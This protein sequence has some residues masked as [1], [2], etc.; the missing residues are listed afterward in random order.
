MVGR[1][2]RFKAMSRRNVRGNILLIVCGISVTLAAG[3]FAVQR[4]MPQLFQQTVHSGDLLTYRMALNSTVDYAAY[5]V[6]QRWCL[7]SNWLQNATC[8]LNDNANTERLLLTDNAIT[9][10]AARS[11]PVIATR[12]SRIEIDIPRSSL[13]EGHPLYIPLK[14][15]P[16]AVTSVLVVVERVDSVFKPTTDQQVFLRVRATLKAPSGEGM[17]ARSSS[18]Y[19]EGF[20]AYYPRE[21]SS[22]ALVVAGDLHLD[23]P[24]MPTSFGADQAGDGYIPYFNKSDIVTGVTFQSPVFVNGA[25][26]LP[27]TADLSANKESPV[28]FSDKIYSG[29]AFSGP[30]QGG[31]L[32]RD[33]SPF[34]P[35]MAS[36]GRMLAMA[37]IKGIRGIRAGIEV[38][39]IRDAGLDYLSGRLAGILQPSLMER[40]VNRNATLTDLVATKDSALMVKPGSTTNTLHIGLSGSLYDRPDPDADTFHYNEFL[41]Q[42]GLA[43][44]AVGASS[45][46]LLAGFPAFTQ[47]AGAKPIMQVTV[48]APTTPAMNIVADMSLGSTVK[49]RFTEASMT[50]GLTGNVTSKQNAVN[51]KLNDMNNDIAD[52]DAAKAAYEAFYAPGAPGE[53]AAPAPPIPADALA[54]PPSG[55]TPPQAADH[56]NLCNAYIAALAA[57]ATSTADHTTAVNELATATAAAGSASAAIN[58]PGSW[59]ELTLEL[60]PISVTEGSFTD[61]QPN[62]A[63]LRLTSVNNGFLPSDF[64]ISLQAYDRGFAAGDG[65]DSRNPNAVGLIP[66][67][68]S[69]TFLKS[70]GPPATALKFSKAGANYQIDP[71]FQPW[72]TTS[73]PTRWKYAHPTSR[74]PADTVL[75]GEYPAAGAKG[76]GPIVDIPF[77]PLSAVSYGGMDT[78]CKQPE[79]ERAFGIPD[80]DYSFADQTR[81]S[82]NFANPSKAPPSTAYYSFDP[83][84]GTLDLPDAPND[85]AFH[86]RS[87]IGRCRIPATATFV[88]G[89]FV[90]DELKIMPRTL[91]LR[92]I[93]SF[94]VSRLNIDK[95]AVKAGINWSNIYNLQAI[96][97]LKAKNILHTNLG[98]GAACNAGTMQPIWHPYPGFN[99]LADLFKCSP[100][101]LRSNADNWT[102]TLVD[103]D[104]GLVCTS[105]SSCE[106]FTSRKSRALRFLLK[107]LSRE[108]NI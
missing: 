34:V 2:L 98:N 36:D 100:V 1:M 108:S 38:D 70:S 21:L 78:R 60:V 72:L 49:V 45:G 32:M 5:T 3:I 50:T 14:A 39:G 16:K 66:A 48:T 90:C 67:T 87:I 23:A 17:L 101:A 25:V 91:P 37:D 29:A 41:P 82:W 93:G 71:T 83:S 74:A 35:G 47:P 80:W 12:L 105:P 28:I 6:K 95:S 54:S 96:E 20:F 11:T 52:R 94:I 9:A 10:L 33:G 26:H 64:N 63:I 103:P 55:L 19:V 31:G 84:M 81:K 40:C 56:T 58:A 99:A 18:L 46:P 86:I 65:T 68:G 88:A 7:T 15:L 106:T 76:L 79:N 61:V 62:Q 53:L 102:W 44:G 59:P 27:S 24:E 30:N 89:F 73:N 8:K 69:N 42:T 104:Q 51:N 92:L 77:P 4:L 97:E 22:M 85:T 57:L 43:G 107:E 13:V 75:P